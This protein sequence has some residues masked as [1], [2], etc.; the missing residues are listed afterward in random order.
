MNEEFY[1]SLFQKK[2]E[3]AIS[4]EEQ[5]SLNAW[6]GES[7]DNRLIAESVE[8]AWKL[9]G[10]YSQNIDIDLDE[11]FAMLE[12]KLEEEEAPEPQIVRMNPRFKWWQV[13]ASIAVII[14]LGFLANNLFFGKVKWDTIQTLSSQKEEIILP[15]GTKIRINQNSS[16]TYPDKFKG[17]SRLVKLEGEA[18][19]EVV[20]NAEMPF[21]IQTQSGASVQ[22]LGTSFN[23]RDYPAEEFVEVQ[24]KTG[25]VRFKPAE[26]IKEELILEAKDK[27]S[28]NKKG[29]QLVKTPDASPNVFAWHSSRLEFD[30]VTL[31]Q[32]IGDIERLF[33]ASIEITNPEMENCPFTSTFENKEIK[34]ILQTIAGVFG[35]EVEETAKNAFRLT[36]GNCQ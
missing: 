14:T 28:F 26:T 21:T 15:D 32:C 29:K 10:D 6:L 27:G 4:P 1:I 8:K 20:G 34:I 36:G 19:F 11:E 12:K 33:D 7:P 16:L 31:L 2:L 30:E 3:G 24:V 35:M 17:K 25:K 9:S 18:F 23:V 13:A 5:T 22:V